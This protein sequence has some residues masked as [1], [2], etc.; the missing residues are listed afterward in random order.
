[1]VSYPK[2][3]KDI[4]E[5]EEITYYYMA[6]LD[7][8]KYSILESTSVHPYINILYLYIEKAPISV[9]HCPKKP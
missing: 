4:S 6:E 8:S 7:L 9:Q 1:M 5:K 3:G 2:K